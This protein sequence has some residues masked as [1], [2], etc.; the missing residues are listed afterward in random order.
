MSPVVTEF[1]DLTSAEKYE[2]VAKNSSTSV[3]NVL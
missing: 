1:H 2:L 3:E